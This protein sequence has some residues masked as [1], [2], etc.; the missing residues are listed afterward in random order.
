MDESIQ[1]GTEKLLLL[2][3]VPLNKEHSHCTALR[4]EDVQVLGMEVQHSWTGDLIAD[5]VGRTLA[6][7]PRLN[8]A[9]LIS[10]RGRLY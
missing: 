2:L 7:F 8:V 1:I 4:G 5:F 3:G 6:G 10:D 9:Y